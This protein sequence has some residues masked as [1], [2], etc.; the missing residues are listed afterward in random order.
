MPTPGIIKFGKARNS[1]ELNRWA[2][3]GPH[4]CSALIRMK[5]VVGASLK[6]LGTS[7]A[8]YAEELRRIFNV[9]LHD[10]SIIEDSL[11]SV[12]GTEN[13]D[14]A[15]SLGSRKFDNVITNNSN[16]SL[17]RILINFENDEKMDKENSKL[18]RQKKRKSTKLMGK[19]AKKLRKEKAK[20][21]TVRNSLFLLN[22]ILNSFAC[23]KH[24]PTKQKTKIVPFLGE[25]AASVK[26]RQKIA[27]EVPWPPPSNGVLYSP[28]EYVTY[29]NDDELTGFGFLKQIHEDLKEVGW[30]EVG[31]TSGKRRANKFS[32][33]PRKGI[34]PWSMF[35]RQTLKVEKEIQ[36]WFTKWMKERS[37]VADDKDWK[38]IICKSCNISN[39]TDCL[40]RKW[41]KRMLALNIHDVRATSSAKPVDLQRFVALDSVRSA[42]TMAMCGDNAFLCRKA[43]ETT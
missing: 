28:L 16:A 29:A 27:N 35:G 37:D 13:F 7:K 36:E 26:R 14:I 30:V 8:K 4:A 3:K 41:K 32:E 33:D 25:K 6:R 2:K 9:L 22:R 34:V 15:Y 19:N 23:M 11:E 31:Y 20:K 43:D 24:A 38:E 5:F 18:H 10:L 39:P 21:K 40:V 17:N 1:A 12:F 42:T